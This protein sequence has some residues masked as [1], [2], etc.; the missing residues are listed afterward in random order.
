MSNTKIIIY[1]RPAFR[2]QGIGEAAKELGV[3]PA[4]IRFYLGGRT[5]TLSKAKR[6]RIVI[7]TMSERKAV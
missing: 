1:R 2:W 6:D 5:E 3:T 7:K 4:A